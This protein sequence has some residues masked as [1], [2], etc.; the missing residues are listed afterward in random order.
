MLILKILTR[1]LIFSTQ[2]SNGYR[3]T[4]TCPSK[5]V[6]NPVKNE[7]DWWSSTPGCGELSNFSK[8]MRFLAKMPYFRKFWSKALETLSIWYPTKCFRY[9]GNDLSPSYMKIRHIRHDFFR[10][11]SMS[12]TTLLARADPGIS[13][14][15]SHLTFRKLTKNGLILINIV[16]FMTGHSTLTPPQIGRLSGQ[17]VN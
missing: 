2:C 15:R 8:I 16:F 4:K 3:V 10:P 11:F 12:D 17:L 7:C 9:L 6:F 5:L 1:F 14:K 13:P